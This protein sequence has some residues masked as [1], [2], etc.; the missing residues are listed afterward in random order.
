MTVTSF[1]P[2]PV[3]ETAGIRRKSSPLSKGTCSL[4]I[5]GLFVVGKFFRAEIVFPIPNAKMSFAEK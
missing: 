1:I 2:R 4:G 3:G 5:G